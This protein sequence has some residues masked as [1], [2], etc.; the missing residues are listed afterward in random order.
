MVVRMELSE[1]EEQLIKSGK[2]KAVL[3]TEPVEEWVGNIC[4]SIDG[5]AYRIIEKRRWTIARIG[6]QRCKVDFGCE[7]IKRFKAVIGYLYGKYA[8]IKNDVVHE[9]CFAPDKKQKTLEGEK[10]ED[11]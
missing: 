9:I 6:A 2:I 7:D 3:R 1:K 4:F 10:K 5:E 11:E 8:K